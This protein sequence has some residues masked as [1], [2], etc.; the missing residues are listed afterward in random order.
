M[1]LKSNAAQ[2]A[3]PTS[4]LHIAR[5]VL[6]REGA[7]RKEQAPATDGAALQQTCVR[8]SENLRDSMGEDACGVLFGKA[9]ARTEQDH[10]ALQD[11]PRL[12][13]GSM[14]LNDVA[15]TVETHGIVAVTAAIESLLAA[16]IDVLSLIIGGDKAIRIIDRE[17]SRWRKAN[18]VTTSRR[19]SDCARGTST[20]T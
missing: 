15:A 5:R 14:R 1:S 16:L 3:Q 20:R 18:P 13:E 9:L 2:S 17:T 7:L 4:S 11:M 6:A 19:R 10:P 12:S 8:V